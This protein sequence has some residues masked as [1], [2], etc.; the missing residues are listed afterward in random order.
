MQTRVFGD[1][2]FNAIGYG[3]MSFSIAYGSVATGEER[4]KV[5]FMSHIGL[6]YLIPFS[7]AGSGYRLRIQ[8]YHLEH[9]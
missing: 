9:R 8:G 6:R 3:G 2:A 1:K 7:I 5:D 4:L